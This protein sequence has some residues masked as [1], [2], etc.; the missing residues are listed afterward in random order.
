MW[1]LFRVRQGLPR[2]MGVT[3]FQSRTR[4]LTV[5]ARSSAVGPQ[6]VIQSSDLMRSNRQWCQQ[7]DVPFALGFPLGNLGEGGHSTQP[8]AF[9]PSPGLDDGG[10]QSIATVGLARA[11]AFYPGA[12]SLHQGEFPKSVTHHG[13]EELVTGACFGPVTRKGVKSKR[14]KMKY[15]I[16]SLVAFGALS[17]SAQAAP[18][19]P[20]PVATQAAPGD[21]VQKVDYYYG[22]Y[23][24][25]WARPW[26]YRRWGYARWGYGPYRPWLGYR[27]YGYGY[28]YRP[29]GYGPW[30]GPWGY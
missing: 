18:T 21:A 5:I 2:L 10:E 30:G 17:V 11:A 20:A 29:W 1:M 16:A 7:A 6:A 15:A 26:G 4:T 24:G 27:P 14:Y 23:G 9:D 3:R 8:D 13:S 22:G 12:G 25:P 28:G 19:S